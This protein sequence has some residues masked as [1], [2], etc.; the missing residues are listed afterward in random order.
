M[1]REHFY[2]SSVKGVLAEEDIA[3]YLSEFIS[4]QK[5][6][7]RVELTGDIAGNMHRNKTG[8]I[9]CHLH[10]DRSTKIAIECKFDKGVRLGDIQSKDVFTK[11]IDTAWSQLLE[12][13]ANRDGNIGI[14]VFDI[15]LVDNSILSVV[16]D[17]K[18]IPSIGFIS[19]ID[20]QKGDYRNLSIAYMLARDIAINS[21]NVELDQN[22]L[23]A[24]INRIIKDLNDIISI[25]SLVYKLEKRR[26][27]K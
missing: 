23:K 10:G 14:I 19:I 13:Q 4:K 7:D 17:V 16:Q 11:K 26:V 2:K 8:D 6:G 9:V 5:L 15:S 24:I 3:D 12:A 18:F 1:K 25:K 21:I 22:I 27:G 20:S